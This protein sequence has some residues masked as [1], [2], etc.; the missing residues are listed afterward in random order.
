MNKL[1]SN[2][3]FNIIFLSHC[4]TVKDNIVLPFSHLLQEIN[5]PFWIDKNNIVPGDNI[6][7]TI[8]NAINYCGY[9]LAFIDEEYLNTHWPMLELNLFKNKN[10]NSIIPVYCGIKKEQVYKWIPWLENIAFERIENNYKFG[11]YEKETLLNRLLNRILSDMDAKMDITAIKRLFIFNNKYVKL[12]NFLESFNY[13]KTTDLLLKCMELC[14]MQLII[15]FVLYQE[16]Y[17]SKTMF[18]IIERYVY[19]VKNLIFEYPSL[20][21]EDTY[22]TLCKGINYSINLLVNTR[23]SI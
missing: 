22:I 6:N 5:I 3:N 17:K 9:C 12:L 19:H 13:Y 14:N 21:T 18:S 4:K 15:L 10:A 11:D 16:F 1:S 23:N 7:K 20:V 2:D 8:K